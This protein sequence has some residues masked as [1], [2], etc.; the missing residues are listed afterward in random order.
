M[1]SPI[2][3]GHDMTRIAWPLIGALAA[4]LSTPA[5]A[6]EKVGT[7]E[8]GA[9]VCELPGDAG[10]QAGVAQPAESFT[11]ISAS[12]YSSPQG[13]GTYLRRGNRV[14]MTSGPRNGDSYVV[15]SSGYLRKLDNGEPGRLRCVR[16]G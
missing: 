5:L 13:D 14:T 9:Y 11:I 4:C 7:L 15:V 16:E 1:L 8:R 6:Q 3:Y 2:C 12:R 10:G